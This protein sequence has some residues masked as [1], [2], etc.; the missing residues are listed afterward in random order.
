MTFSICVREQTKEEAAE[1]SLQFGVAITTRRPSVGNRCPFVSEHGAI[2]TQSHSNPELGAKGLQYLADSLA[3]EDVLPALLNADDGAP[4]RQVHGVDASGAFA[5]SGDECR[6]WYG[7]KYGENF[8]VAGNILTG[9]EV[10]EATATAYETSDRD[11]PL[12][13]R[14]IDSL[15]AGHEAGGDRRDRPIQSAACVVRSSGDAE[16]HPFTRDLRVDATE[17][18]I[19]DLRNVYELAKKAPE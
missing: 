17:S 19:A 4:T 1:E 18:P 9:K 14:L 13:S 16:I 3:I 5:F 15:E 6:E 2:A 10:L 7:H 11:E 12:P 8:T